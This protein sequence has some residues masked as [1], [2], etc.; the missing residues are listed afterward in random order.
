MS[1]ATV[2]LPSSATAAAAT[3]TSSMS[4]SALSFSVFN[5]SIPCFCSCSSS[6][7]SSSSS[8]SVSFSPL[9]NFVYAPTTTRTHRT[10][11]EVALGSD[12]K[13]SSDLSQSPSSSSTDD[14]GAKIGARIRV[15]VPLKV[16]HVPRVPEVDLTGME[17]VLKQY[18]GLWKGKRISANYPYKVEFVI[19]V[20][21]RGS[22]KFFAH[23]K[24]DE[25]EYV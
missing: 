18:V 7:S 17:G 23:L 19:Q 16:H 4:R 21:G 10:R 25:F 8:L 20:E 22:V 6:S 11:C 15:K 3:A 9:C 5:A 2:G 13:T 1:S 12:S 14:L 24:E